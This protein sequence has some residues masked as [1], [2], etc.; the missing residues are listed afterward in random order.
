[1]VKVSFNSALAQKEA[2][3][4]EEENSQ[5]LILPPDAKVRAAG[6]PTLRGRPGGAGR[7]A[8]LRCARRGCPGKGARR[9]RCR[10]FYAPCPRRWPAGGPEEAARP[11]APPPHRLTLLKWLTGS[12]LLGS[13]SPGSGDLCCGSIFLFARSGV[14]V[15]VL[16]WR[17][18][19]VSRVDRGHLG[20]EGRLYARSRSLR[21]CW[22]VWR[23]RVV[24]AFPPPRSLPAA[25]RGP[26]AAGELPEPG[27]SRVRQRSEGEAGDSAAL[28]PQR[29][30]RAWC[31]CASGKFASEL[32]LAEVKEQRAASPPPPNSP[33]TAPK[34]QALLSPPLC[35]Q[36]RRKK[37]QRLLK[38]LKCKTA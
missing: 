22:F 21:L 32:G 12:E 25:R 15:G 33:Q 11:C 6:G 24:P 8:A 14:F 36:Q 7:S 31:L 1:M 9:G 3:K 27:C 23:R 19:F 10:A 16:F 13:A 2:A 34:L 4:K 30:R 18:F 17:V 29:V 20:V 37:H 35:K 5:V 28:V 26:A 38:F